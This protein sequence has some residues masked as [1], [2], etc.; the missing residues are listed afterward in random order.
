[1]AQPARTASRTP[2]SRGA[3]APLDAASPSSRLPAPPWTRIAGTMSLIRGATL[4]G[5]GRRARR[6][7]A[8]GG[9]SRGA[10]WRAPLKDVW[11]SYPP[12]RSEVHMAG[13]EVVVVGAVR[14][15][16]GAFLGS[17]SSV[18]ATRLG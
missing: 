11:G 8:A 12:Q 16:I 3:S 18:P 10:S 2:T 17:L 14:T 15:P 6:P 1:M 13:R 4:A 7:A 9:R 5:A